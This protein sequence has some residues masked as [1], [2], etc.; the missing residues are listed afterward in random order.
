MA[1]QSNQ[2]VQQDDDGSNRA[3]PYRNLPPKERLL[4]KLRD[5]MQKMRKNFN[6]SIHDRFLQ[7]AAEEMDFKKLISSIFEKSTSQNNL[8]LSLD[9]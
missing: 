7:K 6:F 5:R 2:N 4:P 1:M 8:L 9:Q 3:S